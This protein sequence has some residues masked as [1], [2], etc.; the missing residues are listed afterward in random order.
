M[1]S[2]DYSRRAFLAIAG[3]GAVVL[4]G[5]A[6]TQQEQIRAFLL[7]AALNGG[8]Q[9]GS[10]PALPTTANEFANAAQDAVEAGAGAIHIHVR[11]SKENESLRSEDI[12]TVL[13]TVRATI[14]STPIGISTHFGIVGDAEQR[15]EIVSMWSVL[16]DFAS[17]NF[18]E[19]G[20]VTLARLLIE[21]G[22][23]V[24]AG[25][26]NAD[27]AVTCVES[28]LANDCL[29]LMMEPRN[30]DLENALSNVAEMEAVLN[31]AGVVRP[32]L[33]HG[34][35][36]TA[37]PLIEEAT[38]RG[39]ATRAGLEDTFEL[40]DGSTATDN[41][42]IVAEAAHMIANISGAL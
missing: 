17:V 12:A 32:R 34:F 5:C 1:H 23:G 9:P 35:G 16:P 25:L 40:A 13:A 22:V 20:A 26:L 14:P 30:R 28:G 39:Y 10:H 18:N 15:Q 24:E 27:A 37:W 33:L 19:P 36:A 3:A 11:D 4:G 38:R 6:V 42:E 21:N 29:R 41:A 31:A 8:R 7:K 2:S